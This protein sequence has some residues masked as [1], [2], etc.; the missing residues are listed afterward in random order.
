[1]PDPFELYEA[2]LWEPPNGYFL[3]DLHLDRLQRSAAHF[4][5]SVDIGCIRSRLLDYA[6]RLPRE[7]RK[8]RLEVMANGSVFMNDEIVKAGTPV[9]VAL[10][11]EP[12]HS[13]DEFLR[14]KT[15]RREVY[16][17]ALASTPEAQE[18]LLWN[19]RG[20]LTEGCNANLILQIAGRKLTPPVSSGLLPG[21][22]RAY[23]LDRGE[24]EER[25][26]PVNTLQQASD[27][28]FINSVRRWY[29][30]RLMSAT[31]ATS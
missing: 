7:S 28:F 15:S 10:A 17:R 21:V 9:A 2:I 23:L 3:L 26:L 30:A 19:E 24:I 20:E 12:V 1:M 22:F 6:Q 11:R 4:R 25:V 14:H 8:V 16:R 27:V 31:G 13:A 29:E 5:F 18:V